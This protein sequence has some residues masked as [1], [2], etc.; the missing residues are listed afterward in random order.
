MTRCAHFTMNSFRSLAI[1]YVLILLLCIF[2]VIKG[3]RTFRER[4]LTKTPSETSTTSLNDEQPPEQ[5]KPPSKVRISSLDTFRGLAIVTMIFAN[6]GAGRYWWL[7]HVAWN[8]IHFADFIFPSFLWI[9]GVCIPI[10]IKSQLARNVLKKNIIKNI[11]IV[12]VV[13]E[14]SRILQN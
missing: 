5:E 4:R 9:M 14:F 10:S 13:C 1:L 8:G 11:L 7:E 3:L 2:G 6:C 12:S